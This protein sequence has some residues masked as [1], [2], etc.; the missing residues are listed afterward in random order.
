MRILDNLTCLLRNLSISQGAT[1]RIGRRAMDWFQIGKGVHQGYILS[2]CLFA[3]CT[4][5]H[6][7]CRAGLRPNWNQDFRRKYE[8]SQICR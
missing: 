3:L 8:Q 1:V 4:V 2:S 6:V 7:K 5:Q